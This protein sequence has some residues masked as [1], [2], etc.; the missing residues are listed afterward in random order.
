MKWTV[1]INNLFKKFIKEQVCDLEPATTNNFEHSAPSNQLIKTA[2]LHNQIVLP[3][4]LI[5]LHEKPLSGE[6]SKSLSKFFADSRHVKQ[7]AGTMMEMN[8]N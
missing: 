2:S 6:I 3:A 7:L 4:Q 5:I 1:K 8:M